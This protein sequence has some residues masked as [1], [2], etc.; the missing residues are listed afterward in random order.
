MG[1]DDGTPPEQRPEHHEEPED[2]G[3]WRP[4]HSIPSNWS[5]ISYTQEPGPTNEDDR[6]TSTLPRV[7][8]RPDVANMPTRRLRMLHGA[9]APR[10]PLL[11]VGGLV[12]LV[13][14]LA[15]SVFAISRARQNTRTGP[16]RPA[17][18]VGT[19][20]Q[21]ADTY[22]A[23]YTSGNLTA[24]YLLTS[25]ASHKRFDDPK[26][27]GGNYRDAQDYIVSRTQAILD[28]AQIASISATP[29]AVAQRGSASASVPV[30]LVYNSVRVG[31]F[32]QNV[33]LPLVLEQGH[34]HVNWS[35]GLIFSKLDDSTDPTYQRKV[36]M[37]QQ[38]APRG[39]IYDRD[40]NVLAK[41]E[42]AYI[43]EVVPGELKNQDQSLRTLGLA[44]DLTSDQITA[45]LAGHAATDVVPLRTISPQLFA[46]ISVTINGIA[47][48][49]EDT[50]TARIYPYGT[51]AAAVTGYVSIVTADDLKSDQ[52]KHYGQGDYLG[53]AGI[54]GWGEQYLRPTKGGKLEIGT[55]TG[56]GTMDPQSAVV[57]AARDAVAGAD[58]HSTIS[59]T[60]QQ[61]MQ[62][63]LSHQGG[64]GGGSL[65]VDPATGAV[66]AMGSFP[67][68]D[69]NDFSLGFT[70]NEQA[71][72]NALDHPYLNRA[73]GEAQPVG[74]VF[75]VV[76][77]SAG[78]QNGITPN[79]TF[80]CGGSY[81]VPGENH[82]R[83]DD[84][85]TGH[86]TLSAPNA[87]GPSCDVI[88]WQIAVQLN[89]K[90]PNILSN[91]ARGFGFGTRTGIVGISPGEESAGL[92]PDPAYLKSTRNAQW[93]ATDAANLGTGQGFFEATPAQVAVAAAGIANNGVR[94]QPEIVSAVTSA[95][96]TNLVTVGP[97]KAGQ[98]PLSADNLAVVQ[99]AML[100][101][102]YG[103]TGTATQ[104]FVNFPVRVAG[105]TGTAESG[106]E[107]PHGWFEAYAPAS[108]L[109]GPAV[110]A[111]I[112]VG[113]LVEYSDYGEKY[114][115][116]VTKAVIQ[117]YLHLS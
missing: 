7:N 8:A 34:W 72:F 45:K 28:Q 27:L 1:W 81:Q 16:S 43:I 104:D 68:Y 59:I 116:P 14:L 54:E 41:D 65:A 78:L 113:T 15:G 83:I 26:I 20:C 22:L 74:S 88:Y 106:Q 84:L 85:P 67:I 55:L 19:P 87:L 99:A 115:V 49:H 11:I 117:A 44:I 98:V 31:Q 53:R 89:S 69:P 86:G 95:S 79:Q 100:G 60:S 92:V 18:A 107:H 73:L 40:G 29:G 97:K 35:P 52:G 50:T 70:L 62:Q 94:M 93:T 10:R 37:F 80:T 105:K 56:D 24:A 102:T 77:L 90:D 75:K 64:F 9:G 48:V 63:A 111:Q 110:P 36:R 46:S 112:A 6:P 76:T 91:E 42:T 61:A 47:G 103:A 4:A 71:R 17:C 38:D 114:A 2:D 30:R 51:D 96:G 58:I 13:A 57:V 109:A 5:G 39:T 25:D 21:V 23:D 82:L 32:T 101:P 12:L 33:T 66:I 108:P 3:Y